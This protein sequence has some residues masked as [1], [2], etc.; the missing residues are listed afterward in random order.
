MA[1][2]RVAEL[3]RILALN[4]ADIIEY[5]LCI[6]GLIDG[7]N[8]C[9]FCED[10]EECQLEAKEQMGCGEWMMRSQMKREAAAAKEAEEEKPV[11]LTD[12]VKIE[13]AGDP[14]GQEETA[15]DDSIQ[16]MEEQ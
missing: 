11:I 16:C 12:P 4:R 5:N 8:P 1:S 15:G 14:D 7:K 2:L 9:M 13:E 10:Y 6:L 3:E